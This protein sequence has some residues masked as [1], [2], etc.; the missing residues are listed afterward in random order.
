MERWVEIT[1]YCPDCQGI[2][3]EHYPKEEFD[4]RLSVIE[5]PYCGYECCYPNDK[6]D[7]REIETTDELDFSEEEPIDFDFASKV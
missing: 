1:F 4:N 6:I 3:I 7:E 5:C 2:W